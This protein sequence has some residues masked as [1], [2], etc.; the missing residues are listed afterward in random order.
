VRAGINFSIVLGA[1]CF[2][3]GSLESILLSQIPESDDQSPL[4]RRLLADLRQ[5]V[6]MTTGAERFNNLFAL[7]AGRTALAL[8]NDQELWEA[9]KVLF[10]FRN[11]IAHAR[12]VRYDLLSPPGIGGYWE[13]EFSGGYKQVEDF[14]LRKGMIES[15]HVEEADNLFY[16]RD[17][18]AD[19]F[20]DKACRFVEAIRTNIV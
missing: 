19:F 11:M 12:A 14:L 2:V 17:N 3:E 16:F 1:T 15:R 10:H 20:W 5:R 4:V 9:T 8:V 13:E 6:G 7:V 18:V